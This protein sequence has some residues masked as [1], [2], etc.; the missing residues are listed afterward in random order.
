MRGDR[1]PEPG[2]E[3]VWGALS[4]ALRKAQY[5]ELWL[6]FRPRGSK[7]VFDAVAAA[8]EVANQEVEDAGW[9]DDV[10]TGGVSDSDAGPV[11]FMS[12]AKSKEGV[13][14]WLAVFARHLQTQGL[15]GRVTAAPEAFFPD[16]LSG[17]VEVPRQLTAFVSYQTNDLALLDADEERRAWHVPAALTAKV[18]DAA[19]AWG[20]FNGADV[21]LLR[22]IHQTRS[23]NPDA[24]S[25]LAGAAVQFA[26]GRVVYLRSQPRRLV[27]ASLGALG[28]A[29]YG[30][31]DDT[32]SWQDR[33]AQVVR[34][35]VAFPEDT[36]LAF[37]Q[38]SSALELGWSGLYTVRPV[39]PYVEEYHIRY[40]RHLNG[41]YI[42]DAH[43]LQL[44]TDAHLAHANDLSDWIIEP[45]GAGKHLVQATD[46]EPWYATIEPDPETL[47]KARADFGGMILTP[48]IIAANPPP[49]R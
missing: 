38:Y 2:V 17:E 16:W 20:R 12:R 3:V 36:D 5:E 33:L 47:A 40:S 44:L 29:S 32:V 11:A 27:W 30:V 1:L 25:A 31:L 22:Y 7:D 21:Y 4:R 6:Q 15:S 39:L 48:E 37:V 24:G 41:Q 23:K 43:G 13:R 19:T 28:R 26:M 10:F 46:L 45:L 35:M 34:A 14:V 49:W 42:A 18:A 9:G 8:V